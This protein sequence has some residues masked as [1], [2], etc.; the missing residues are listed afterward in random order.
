MMSFRVGEAERCV[1]DRLLKLLNA[2][3]LLGNPNQ[4]CGSLGNQMGTGAAA[5]CLPSGRI[6]FGVVL[7]LSP[8]VPHPLPIGK[9]Q[10]MEVLWEFLNLALAELD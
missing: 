10:I 7:Q 1:I 2:V 9:P 5:P 8:R 4:Y 6:S 3:T